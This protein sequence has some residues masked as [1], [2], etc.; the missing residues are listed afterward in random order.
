MKRFVI[1]IAALCLLMGCER[2]ASVIVPVVEEDVANPDSTI[3]FQ[4]VTGFMYKDHYW[5]MFEKYS[6]RGGITF[7]DIEHDPNCW[8]VSGIEYD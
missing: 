8:C 1:L 4:S 7:Y 3:G 2:K 6:T 5:L